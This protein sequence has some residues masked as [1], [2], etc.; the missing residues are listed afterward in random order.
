MAN[1]LE[2]ELKRTD[3]KGITRLSYDPESFKVVVTLD[4]V[5]TYIGAYSSLN[6]ALKARKH[7][8]RGQGF[9]PSCYPRRHS[10]ANV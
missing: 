8:L 10:S 2:I 9:I 6:K 1:K 7:A 3:L 5:V 4:G